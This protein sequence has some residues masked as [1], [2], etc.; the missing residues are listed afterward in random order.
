VLAGVRAQAYLTLTPEY[1]QTAVPTATGSGSRGP[2]EPQLGQTRREAQLAAR[3]DAWWQKTRYRGKHDW[4]SVLDHDILGYVAHAT[5]NLAAVVADP[6]GATCVCCLQHPAVTMQT[7]IVHTATVLCELC[8]C[9]AVIPTSVISNST[10]LAAWH[11]A[12][13]QTLTN[14]RTIEERCYERFAKFCDE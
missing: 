11:A 7:C 5:N 12:G 8:G 14:Y 9:D 6:V 1:V 2:H 4:P 13:F 10:T 3:G